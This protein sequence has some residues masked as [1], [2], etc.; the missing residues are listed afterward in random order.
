MPEMDEGALILDYE[1]PGRHFAAGKPTK[2]CGVWRRSCREPPDVSGYIRRT[3]AEN[4]LFVTESFRGDIL[5]SL[6]PPGQRRPMKEILDS[7]REDIKQAVPELETSELMPLIQDQ[8]RRH[9]RLAA[10]G[11]DQSIRPRSS[12]S[13]A[14]L[15]EQSS[16]SGR[17]TEARGSE[18]SRAV[19][20]PRFGGAA[21]QRANARLGLD[22]AGR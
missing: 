2:C 12:R 20:K 10:G 19:G 8:I 17:R 18:R 7:L 3:G 16:R 5:V 9:G 13:C 1:M 15:A 6:K 14:T 4:G 22:G 11:G 21:R